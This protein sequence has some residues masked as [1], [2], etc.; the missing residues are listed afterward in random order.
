MSRFSSIQLE[1][2]TQNVPIDPV[3]GDYKY[4]FDINVYSMNYNIL[5]IISGQGNVEFSN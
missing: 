1:M 3:T 4:K 2:E 5:R